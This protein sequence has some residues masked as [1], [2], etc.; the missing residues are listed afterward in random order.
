MTALAKP[1]G[2]PDDRRRV[3]YYPG[4]SLEA[5]ARDY[6]ESVAGA[7]QLLGVELNEVPDWN[8]CGATAAHSL[9]HR[10]TLN[11][12]A[13]NLALAAKCPSPLVVPCALCFNR[14]KSAQAE[15]A[16]DTSQV[17]P[18]IAGLGGDYGSAQVKELNSFLSEDWAVEKAR[19]LKQ[20]DLT[21]LRP[22]C[23]YGCQ[24]QRPPAVTGHPEPEN[25]MGLDRLLTALGASV[26]DWPYKTDCC[27]ASHAVPRPDIVHTLVARLYERA[28]AAGANCLV[29]GCQMCQANLDLYQQ[30]IAREMGREVYLPVFYFTEL[31]GLALGHP[32]A[33]R[34]LDRH[35]TSPRPLLAAAGLA[36]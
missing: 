6:A 22:V 15:L 4:C 9:D 8:C 36:L 28:L 16:R 3:G 13:R 5:T 27:G 2:Q 14:L 31:L 21:G 24:G 35:M 12:A 32:Q 23:Y 1:S 17:I 26:R 11:L 18:E 7:A 33:G 34:W 10:A 30:E 20:R 25:P 29:T 19:R